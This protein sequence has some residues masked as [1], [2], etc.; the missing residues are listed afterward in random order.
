[1]KNR[2]I[3][4][5]FFAIKNI[6]PN[7]A[8]L[9]SIQSCIVI[10]KRMN[11][12]YAKI[13]LIAAALAS[14]ATFA[15]ASTGLSA[16]ESSS[17]SEAQDIEEE[18]KATAKQ[19]FQIGKSNLVPTK[20]FINL[21]A[22]AD[23]LYRHGELLKIDLVGTASPDGP[24]ALNERLARER[25][26][27]VKQYFMNH[28]SFPASIFNV[29]T[30]GED[31]CGL[32]KL[33][34]KLPGINN[35]EAILNIIRNTPNRDEAEMRLRT[36]DNGKVWA[37]LA[38]EVFP[39]LRAVK[40]T[41]EGKYITLTHEIS[42]APVEVAEEAVPTEPEIMVPDEEMAIGVI[43]VDADEEPEDYWHR[44]L[45]LKTNAPAWFMLWINGGIEIDMAPH[46]S[47]ELP[48]YYSGFNYFTRYIKFRT[49]AVQPELR[50]WPKR[51]NNGF[52]IGAHFGL[53]WYNCAFDGDSRY[54]DHNRRTPAIG[55]GAS[56]GYRFNFCRNHNWK[57]E[58]TV[59]YGVYKLDYDIFNNV[60][61][62]LITGRRQRTF[63]GIDRAA[64]SFCY[65]FDL[66]K[67]KGGNK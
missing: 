5:F 35:R 36:L 16:T 54:Q 40:T 28:G 39:R 60:T 14:G 21:V 1:M 6:L 59:G 43:D 64:L 56:I 2:E 24:L 8:K 55:G 7:F 31:W 18:V 25:A 10:D 20:S 58:V 49:L 41:V 4:N 52:F 22:T 38:S 45:T 42:S 32:E 57:M 48:I 19:D 66:N 33:V 61:N 12:K 34:E 50:Y 37:Q 65:Q 11:F 29:K 44:H 15:S 63:Y 51:D 3:F 27:S 47:A 13:T 17:P 9:I 23:S 62:G 26:A 67:K 46:F 53:G 30:I